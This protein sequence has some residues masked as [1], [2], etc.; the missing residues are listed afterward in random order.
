[1]TDFSCSLN[2]A[3]VRSLFKKYIDE[4]AFLTAYY[5]HIATI[6]AE[7]ENIRRFFSPTPTNGDEFVITKKG[8]AKSQIRKIIRGD[9]RR[10]LKLKVIINK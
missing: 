4:H 7:K 2:E 5:L 9:F 6:I 10:Y 8:V 3:E 1:M